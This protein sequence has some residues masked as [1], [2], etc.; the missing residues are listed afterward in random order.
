MGAEL[1][2]S[3]VE[4]EQTTEPR[5]PAHW[6][7]TGSRRTVNQGVLQTLMVP[8][9]VVVCNEIRPR[10]SEVGLSERNDPVQ[11]FFLQ[12]PHEAFRVGIRVRRLIR[13]LHHAH[14]A[15]LESFAH[16]RAPL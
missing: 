3:L 10:S 11:T 15:L 8:F 16:G 2:S 7:G 9:T 4:V 1:R 13:R 5:L 12:R 6:T 14:P